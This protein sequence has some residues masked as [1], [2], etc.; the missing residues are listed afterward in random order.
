[1]KKYLRQMT[2]RNDLGPSY[3]KLQMTSDNFLLGN[4]KHIN[5]PPQISLPNTKNLKPRIQK[6]TVI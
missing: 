5:L 6:S 3:A 4:V 1:M 2:G